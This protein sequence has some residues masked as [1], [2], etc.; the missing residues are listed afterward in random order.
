MATRTAPARFDVHQHHGL[1][2]KALR[3]SVQRGECLLT[4]AQVADESQCEVAR[5]L[6]MDG[7]GFRSE[8]ARELHREL[9]VEAACVLMRLARCDKASAEARFEDRYLKISDTLHFELLGTRLL[10]P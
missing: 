8:R 9:H 1:L 2:V 3:Q 5:Q 7:G 4:V 10:N 6:G